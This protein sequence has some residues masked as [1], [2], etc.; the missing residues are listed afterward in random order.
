MSTEETLQGVAGENKRALLF[1]RETETPTRTS[2]AFGDA[3]DVTGHWRDGLEGPPEP[4]DDVLELQQDLTGR[5][6]LLGVLRQALV[7]EYLPGP[8]ADIGD[9]GLLYKRPGA[10]CCCVPL[11]LCAVDE[12]LAAEPHTAPEGRTKH[13]P[14]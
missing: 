4:L 9:Q 2:D 12:C 13:I 8:S 3:V 10:S 14:A 11:A 5:R 6:P 1:I 7:Q